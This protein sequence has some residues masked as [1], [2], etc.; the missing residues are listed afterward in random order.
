MEGVTINGVT[1]NYFYTKVPLVNLGAV[2]GTV[3]LTITGTSEKGSV[4]GNGD[5]NTGNVYGGGDASMVSDT[6]DPAN[7]KTIV[8]LKGKTEVKG[9]VFGGGNQG[10]VSGS[11]IV[12]IEQ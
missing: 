12:N 9:N 6:T 2:S 8:T 4:I 11:T 7:A 1:K 5:A 10:Y 3:K